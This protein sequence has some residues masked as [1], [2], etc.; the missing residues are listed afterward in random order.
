LGKEIGKVYTND[1]IVKRHGTLKHSHIIKT[2]ILQEAVEKCGEYVFF[3]I[4]GGNLLI[5]KAV[6]DIIQPAT[7][8]VFSTAILKEFLNKTGLKDSKEE[9]SELQ[10]W[11]DDYTF[12]IK[13]GS[14]SL[15]K[16]WPCPPYCEFK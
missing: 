12:A 14:H 1:E 2:S 16:S 7:F 10:I 15:Q 9:Y 4:S 3:N 6:D 13:N 11:S 8:H 5:A